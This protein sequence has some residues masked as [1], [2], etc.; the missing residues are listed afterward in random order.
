MPFREWITLRNLLYIAPLLAVCIAGIALLVDVAS[1]FRT[2][3]LPSDESRHE[4]NEIDLLREIDFRVSRVQKVFDGQTIKDAPDMCELETSIYVVAK[5]G[6]IALRPPPRDDQTVW[7]GSS[8][9]GY[10]HLPSSAPSQFEAYVERNLPQLVEDYLQCK[11]DDE[12]GHL[13]VEDAVNRFNNEVESGIQGIE[14]CSGGM[15]QW[16]REVTAAWQLV[17]TVTKAPIN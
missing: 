7:I 15:E 3:P 4:C 9:Y 11:G 1:L 5:L 2:D 14:Q 8:G 17:R 6:G 12:V 10:R 13:P 16:K